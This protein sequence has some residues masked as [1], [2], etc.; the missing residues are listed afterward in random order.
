MKHLLRK[1]NMIAYRQSKL[2][3]HIKIS[4]RICILAPRF[5][6]TRKLE[7]RIRILLNYWDGCRAC[8]VDHDERRFHAI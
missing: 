5:Q 1:N 4:K 7:R 3:F 8:F 2:E 6:N